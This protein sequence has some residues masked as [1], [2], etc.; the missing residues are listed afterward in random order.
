M[1]YT[2][3]ITQIFDPIARLVIPIWIYTKEVKA[4]METNPV[5]LEIKII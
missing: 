2:A 1:I 4:E 3:V 5:T